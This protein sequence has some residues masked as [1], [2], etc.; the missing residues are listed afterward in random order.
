VVEPSSRAD[1]G[2]A[3]IAFGLLVF[4]RFAPWLVVLITAGAGAVIAGV[5]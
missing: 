3:L 4:W 1:F 2:L 5:A